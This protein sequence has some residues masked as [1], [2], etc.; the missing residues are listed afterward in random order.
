MMIRSAVVNGALGSVGLALA[1]VLLKKGIRT[2]AVVYPGDERIAKIPAGA[3]IVPCDMREIGRLKEL[4]PEPADAFFHLAWMATIGPG[5]DDMLLQTE[6]IRCAIEAVN[7]AAGLNCGVFVGVGSQAEHGRI[8]GFVR[9]DSPC[10]PVTGY[11]MAKLCAGEMTRFVCRQKGIRHV[12]ARILSVYGPHDGPLSVTSVIM[13]KLFAG[14]KPSLT[15]GEQKWDYLYADDAAEGLICM[16]E[17]GKD[18]A[19]YPL[20]TGEVKP[21]RE[22]FEMIR[23]AID[24]E[25]PLG[26]GEI[27]YAPGQVMHLQADLTS[28]REDTGFEPKV[29]FREGIARTV[30]VRRS[31][32]NGNPARKG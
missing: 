13:D 11:G 9:P 6:N 17:R 24:P 1:D 29:S 14:E 30:E 19:V 16:A 15:A 31:L 32:R 3:E 7:A 20:G 8:E 18:G 2:Y 10:F 4:I 5:R 26:L 22:Y 21:L 25:L 12:W 23:D 27:P 28:L